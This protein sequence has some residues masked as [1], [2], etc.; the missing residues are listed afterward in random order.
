MELPT[1]IASKPAFGMAPYEAFYGRKCQS[2]LHWNKVNEQ[3]TLGPEVLQE[4][5]E[6]VRIVRQQLLTPRGWQK[7]YV[8]KRRRDLTFS[9]RDDVFNRILPTMGVVRCGM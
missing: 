7:S 8:D 6:K 4:V 5:E 2:P 3:S 9:I 1:T